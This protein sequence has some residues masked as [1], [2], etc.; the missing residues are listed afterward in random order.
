MTAH[1]RLIKTNCQGR[2]SG[3]L[4]VRMDE[5]SQVIDERG[6]NG[7]ASLHPVDTA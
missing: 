7:W 2:R 3:F 6:M 5:N 4:E 1:P